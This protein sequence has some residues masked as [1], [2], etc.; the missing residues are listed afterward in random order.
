MPLT[1]SNG[2][3]SVSREGTG[4][5]IWLVLG[6]YLLIGFAAYFNILRNYFVADD[7]PFLH[8][9]ASSSSIGVVFAPLAERYFRPAVVALYYINYQVAG[10]SPLAYHVSL[11]LIHVCNTWLVFL[12]ARRLAP[13]RSLHVSVL[14]GLL[15]LLFGGH[16]E[17]V[18]WTAGAADPLLTL[19]AL[20]G[21]LLFLRW[22]EPGASRWW[23]VGVWISFG[24]ALFSKELSAVFPGLLAVVG[25]LGRPTRPDKAI[26]RKIIIA[27]SVPVLLLIGYPLVR[28]LVLG[29]PFVTLAGLGTSPDLLQSARRF[30]LRTFFPPG[31]MIQVIRYRLL[32]VLVIVPAALILL[33]WVARADYRPLALFGLCFALA[34][35]PM[36]PLSISIDTTESERFIYLATVFSCLLTVWFVDSVFKHRALVTAMVVAW[37]AV[38]GVALTR[39]NHNLR[40]ASALARSVL[41]TFGD[42]VRANG[43]LGT[44]IFVLNAVDDV[45]GAYVFRRGFHE[46]L[47]LTAPDQAGA[48]AQTYMLSVHAVT[49]VAEPIR[50]VQ[51]GRTV[52]VELGA[53]APLLGVQT[54]DTKWYRFTRWAATSFTV[55]FSDAARDG[56]ILYLTPTTTAMVGRVP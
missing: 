8:L 6:L 12:L 13:A 7:F 34:I 45:R 40:E 23:I 43:K 14:S 32:D 15:F 19:F 36:V 49:N 56:L 1:V 47:A 55:E 51:R 4:L 39:S 11:L 52:D 25:V 44:P 41:T 2:A 5:T 21:L 54:A 22:L 35:G 24:G 53:G 33:R 3:P 10:L 17:A 42:V 37:C 50:V 26:V 31:W 16:A 9:V 28:S 20:T 18:S 29:F 46:G 48:M 27:I 38:H 30:I